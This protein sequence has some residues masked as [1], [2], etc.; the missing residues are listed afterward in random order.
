[1]KPV[2][3]N[4]ALIAALLLALAEVQSA[5]EVKTIRKMVADEGGGNR[6][7]LLEVALLKAADSRVHNLSRR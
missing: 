7:Q 3:L 1:M 6:M 2:E 4:R 5:A